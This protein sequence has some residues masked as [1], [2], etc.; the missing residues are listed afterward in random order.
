MKG[1]V[2][3]VNLSKSGKSYQVQIGGQG[4]FA[5]LDSKL[6][7]ALGKTIDFSVDPSEYKGKVVN[8]VKEWDID[9]ALTLPT[10]SA[11]TPTPAPMPAPMPAAYALPRDRWYMPF[12]SNT[13]A[14]AITAGLVKDSPSLAQWATAAYRAAM[15]IE[16]AF[17]NRTTPKADSFDS[18]EPDF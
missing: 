12:I 16:N 17:L 8:W 7:Q 2:D 5:K 10:P 6:D 4:Y 15:Q 18:G 9:R 1:L 11:P 13:V 3:S 14:H